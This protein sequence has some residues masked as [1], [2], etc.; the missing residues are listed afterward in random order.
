[1]EVYCATLYLHANLLSRR[2]L[3]APT[4]PTQY[5]NGK[6]ILSKTILQRSHRGYIPID[7]A[8]V[9]AGFERELRGLERVLHWEV[10][11]H[12]E[13][14]TLQLCGEQYSSDL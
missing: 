8:V 14:T 9:D 1:V 6:S 4:L 3:T 2:N 13:N 11:V 7:V 12:K 10:D 5:F